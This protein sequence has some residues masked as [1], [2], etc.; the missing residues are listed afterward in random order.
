MSFHRVYERLAH[1]ARRTNP[2]FCYVRQQDLKDLLRYFDL[3][4]AEASRL[5]QELADL[6]RPK[7]DDGIP[8]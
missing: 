2:N 1:Q 3:V 6:Q 4:E 5:R 8:L 7:D